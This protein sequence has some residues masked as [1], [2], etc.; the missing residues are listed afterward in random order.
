VCELCI[1]DTGIC[2]GGKT[3]RRMSIGGGDARCSNIGGGDAGPHMFLGGGSAV[4][5]RGGDSGSGDGDV[6]AVYIVWTDV[7]YDCA[8]SE[9]GREGSSERGS[10]CCCAGAV[11]LVWGATPG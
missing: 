10:C 9:R 5:S 7:T 2:G 1:A 6:R 3:S 8:V 4:G 11:G